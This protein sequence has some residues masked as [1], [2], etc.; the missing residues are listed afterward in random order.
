[1]RTKLLY[2]KFRQF[3]RGVFSVIRK[4]LQNARKDLG[5]T[6]QEVADK[7]GISLVY[8]QKIEA[9][10]RVGDFALWDALEDLTG[11]HQRKLRSIEETRP[12][13]AG[14]PLGP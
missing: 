7:L 12:V 6:Q 11:I 10:T 9:G 14:S 5:M 4:I 3:A 13:Q 1:M 2:Q 8:Y